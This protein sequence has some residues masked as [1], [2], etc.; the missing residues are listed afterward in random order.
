MTPMRGACRPILKAVRRC[1]AALVTCLFVVMATTDGFLCPDGCAD[2]S[3]VQ[4][5]APHPASPCAFCHGWSAPSVVVPS[6]PAPDL[7]APAAPPAPRLC[8]P[9]LPTPERPPKAA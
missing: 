6:S 7:L 9:A 2:E 1:L 5:A 3:P 4:A 8:A